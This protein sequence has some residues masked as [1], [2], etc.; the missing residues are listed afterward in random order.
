MHDVLTMM[1][2]TEQEC[3]SHTCK[4]EKKEEK[5]QHLI[6]AT[7]HICFIVLEPILNVKRPL[8]LICFVKGGPLQGSSA[9]LARWFDT[10][11]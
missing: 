1:K 11:L 7:S 6:R 3:H 8:H 2:C 9:P 4:K 5:K 10:I